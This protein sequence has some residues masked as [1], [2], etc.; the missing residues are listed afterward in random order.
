MLPILIGEY[1]QDPKPITM[2]IH[3]AGD[4]PG[5]GMEVIVH[6]G[7]GTAA[8]AGVQAFHGVG[9]DL[10]AGAGEART[11]G[12]DILRIG[13]IMTRSGAVIMATLG[14]T[15]AAIGAVTTTDL[16]EKPE[17]MVDSVTRG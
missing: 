16:I 14:A 4:I 2:T 3:G 7:A 9:A 12:M 10:S 17:L 6:I 5:A 8:G 11:G 15:E 13:G 1:M